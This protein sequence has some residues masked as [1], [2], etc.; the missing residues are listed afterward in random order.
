MNARPRYLLCPPD[1]FQVRYVI[2]PWMRG[3]VGRAD[4]GRARRQ[5]EAWRAALAEFAD[6]EAVPPA[7]EQP[8]MPFAANAGLVLGEVFIPARMRFPQRQGETPRFRDWFKRRGYRV[9]ELEDAGSFE[10]EGDALFQP[11]E[12]LLWCGY[13][14][15]SSLQVYRQLAALLDVEI[16]LLRLVDERFYHLDTCL[17]PLPDGRAMYYPEAFD[18]ESVET[19]RRRFAPERRLEIGAEDALRLACNAVVLGR[20]LLLHGAGPELRQ[21]LSAWGLQTRVCPLSEF[22]LAGGSAKCLALCLSH[23]PAPGRRTPSEAD[24]GV[25]DRLV[26]LQGPLLD[27]GLMNAA[28]DC[29]I[30]GGGSF[31]VEHFSAGLRRDQDSWAR[32][33]VFAPSA[34]RLETVV[35]RLLQLGAR[36]A[37]EERDARLEIVTQPGVAPEHFYST[38]IYPTLVRIG[39]RWVR[40][41]RQRMDA[42]LVL[43]EGSEPG[44]RCVLPRQLLPGQKVVCGV[45]GIRV[46]SGGTAP[47]TEGFEFMGSEV[48]SERRVEAAIRRIAWEMRRVRA[49]K[50]RIVVVAGPVVIH[51]GGGP[52][53][54][55]L[56]QLGY[57]QALLGGNAIAAHDIEQALFGT[58]LGVDLKRGVNVHGGHRHHL[59]AINLVRRCGGIVEA[60]RQ[61]HL[62]R[63]VFYELV[64]RG[65]AFAL[66]GSIRD[67]GPLPE[68][69]TDMIAAQDEYARLIEGAEMIL[70]LASMLHAIGVG[71]MTPAGVRLIC[72]DINPAVVTKLADRGSMETVG[73]VT[74]VGLFLNLLTRALEGEADEE[75]PSE[76]EP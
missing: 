70:L 24:F 67:D 69:W 59:E 63:G 76:A 60:V 30:E 54:A 49:R 51:T 41:R 1:F 50:G 55:R 12:P 42:L 11:G 25:R 32:L 27:S 35:G 37:E 31:E 10:G 16:A 14:V 57:V 45:E 74:D 6:L 65:I 73:V 47:R 72:V 43:E 66:A 64:Q 13:G 62:R 9:V 20:V 48:S 33:R 18:Q 17:C 61:G 26:E 23:A 46:L 8:D 34:A 39:G 53:L 58:S 7:E 38:T 5:W 19:L 56:V 68:T 40:A 52:Y 22:L 21:R 29:V 3:N 4:P 15:R 28:L 36:V 75:A 71:N 2:N 44:V